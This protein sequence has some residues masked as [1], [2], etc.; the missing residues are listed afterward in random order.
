M[1]LVWVG[2]C[3]GGWER[4]AP[5][6]HCGGDF[7]GFGSLTSHPP[8]S[9]QPRDSISLSGQYNTS[10]M[11]GVFNGAPFLVLLVAVAVYVVIHGGMDVSTAFVSLSLFTILKTPMAFFPV[12]VGIVM[13]AVKAVKRVEAFLLLDE[14]APGEQ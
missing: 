1:K 5:V 2:E 13:M 4:G 9:P 14:T 7:C 10:A 3:I 6:R 8:F 12:I 11:V